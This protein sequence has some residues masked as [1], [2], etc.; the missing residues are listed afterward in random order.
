MTMS[1]DGKA[2]ADMKVT[3]TGDGCNGDDFNQQWR[4]PTFTRMYFGWEAYAQDAAQTVWVD[5]AAVDKAIID[6]PK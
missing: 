4:A 3:N 5:D 2:V 1:V 6:C